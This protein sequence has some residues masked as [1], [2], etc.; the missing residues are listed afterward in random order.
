MGVPRL[1]PWVVKYFQHDIYKYVE[2]EK[3][4][5]YWPK[6][7]NNLY[8]DSNAFI[9][10]AA[11]RVYCYGN[12][13]NSKDIYEGFTEDQRRTKIFELYWDKILNIINN[14]IIPTKTLY[15]AIDGCAPIAKQ[16]QQ[17]QRRFM[18]SKIP[19]KQSYPKFSLSNKITQ[20]LPKFDTCSITPGTIF[21][22]ELT[23]YI[24][25][26]IR[27]TMINMNSN[28]KIIF[29][30]PTIPGEGEHKIMNHIRSLSE[31]KKIKESHCMVGPDGDLIM[32]T[33]ALTNVVKNIY[34][35]REDLNLRNGDYYY[36]NMTSV[37]QNLAVLFSY[38]KHIINDFILIGFIVGNDFL[39]K[40]QMFMYLEDG[41]DKM[42]DIYQ[43]LIVETD[44]NFYIT[45]NGNINYKNLSL[46][47]N[48]I[49]EN[50]EEYLA[51]QGIMK[52]NEKLI[53]H[54]L[55]RH[56]KIT[57]N[58]IVE[59][60]YIR[61]R[62]DYYIKALK[63]H[64]NIDNIDIEQFITTMCID[65]LKCISWV[66]KYYTNTLVS[67]RFQYGWH[68]PP[69]MIDISSTL[70]KLIND[71]NIN[72]LELFDLGEPTIPFVQLLCVL[73]EKSN[74]LLPDHLK[75]LINDKTSPLHNQGYYPQNFDID[76]EGV[77]AEYAGIALLPFVDINFIEDQYNSCKSTKKYKRNEL[78]KDELF[79]KD[80]NKI[81]KYISDY[82][83][84]EKCNIKKNYL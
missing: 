22:F 57:S 62:R 24:H 44:N 82:G 10:D 36:L 9:H 43:E 28:L 26:Q 25:Y 79:I 8:I 20:E 13:E 29:S 15:I 84:I 68:Y 60:D 34:L 2:R 40:I 65:Y 21:M 19:K 58:G 50:E 77:H 74:N 45:D 46:F 47:F 55:L 27:N 52:V 12:Y 17:R 4:K 11:Q 14:I 37:S 73:P 70:T 75:K 35:L 66:F 32:L 23:K 76:M 81:I 78:G 64:V 48:R 18:S 3:N 1:F 83:T 63:H 72:I 49:A 61:Y 59:F 71:N 69:L 41:L 51:S 42:L 6:Y 39:G 16:A 54:T 30:P 56:V 67:W 53:N 7:I 31:D 80:N 5:K 38:D 33:L